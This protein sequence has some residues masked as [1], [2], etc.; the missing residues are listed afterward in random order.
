M[1]NDRSQLY[2]YPIVGRT[3]LCNMLFPW[4]RAVLFARRRGCAILAPQWTNFNRIG[5]WLRRERD[6]RYYISQFTN[7][8]YIKGLKKIAISVKYCR[9]K[10][11][12][13]DENVSNI[14]SGIV[15]F[16]GL[17]GY[18][19]GLIGHQHFLQKELYKIANE[20]II[21][22][23]NLL[24]KK[25]IGVH[26]RRGDFISTGQ[27]LSLDYYKRA[28]D[29]AF[30]IMQC[31]VPVLIFSDGSEDDLSCLRDSPNVVFM[32]KATALHDLLALSMSSILV[33]TNHSSFSEWAAFL[34]SIPA[35][36]D[37]NGRL[38]SCD[39]MNIFV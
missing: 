38:P 29:E 3:G 14:N 8:G 20:K 36:W 32:P 23:L 15:V 18:F 19:D 37:K 28:I 2:A 5:P 11:N 22:S 24:P 21:S 35:I 34:G 4:A 7:N 17:E 1:I 12:E 27:G 26:I 10:I 13:Y 16:R 25:F 9:K 33:G 30:K 39:F 6:K 31:D